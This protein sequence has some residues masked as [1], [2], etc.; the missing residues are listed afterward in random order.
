MSFFLPALSR[1]FE[2]ATY[3]LAALA[4]VCL[5]L[6]MVVIA[7]AVVMRYAVGQPILGAN[8][9]LQMT[10]TAMVM[11][12]LPYCTFHNGHVAVDVF[13]TALGRWGRLIGDLTSRLLSGFALAILCRRAALRALDAHEFGDTTNMLGLPLWPFY[14]VLAAGT[15]LCVLIFAQQ[16]LARLFGGTPAPQEPPQ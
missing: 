8:E 10:A 9:I 5:V 3:A 15:G 7:A 12:A 16:I 14:A 4:G 6:I 11:A 2:R 1:L 13:D